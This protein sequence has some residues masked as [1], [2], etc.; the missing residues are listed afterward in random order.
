MYLI[1]LTRC[2]SEALLQAVRYSIYPIPWSGWAWG[3]IQSEHLHR[4]ICSQQSTVNSQPSTLNNNH[5]TAKTQRY[6][7]N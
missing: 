5:I 2:D 4:A 3:Q 6:F 1:I 7:L